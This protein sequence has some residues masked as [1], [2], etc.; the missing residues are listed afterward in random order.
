MN[1]AS[2]NIFWLLLP[3]AGAISLVYAAS[4]HESWKR[5]W[6]HAARLSMTILGLMAATTFLLLLLHS[7]G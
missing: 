3:L 2:I 6:W 4:R 7:R 5:I 1:P